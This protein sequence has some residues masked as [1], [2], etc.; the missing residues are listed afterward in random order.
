MDIF[1]ARQPIFDLHNQLFGYELLYRASSAVNAAE[2][3]TRDQMSSTV[4]ARSIIDIGLERITG[5]RIGFLNFSR[6]TLLEGFAELLSAG[7][8]VIEL[9]ETIE[10]EPAVVE[11]CQRL[12]RLGYTLAL[13]DF[14]YHP[15]YDALIRQ[16]QIVKLDVLNRSGEEIERLVAP[17]R[18]YGVRLL[19][20]R[21]ED[22]EVY[23][24]CR[25]LGCELFQGYH[26]SRP[27]ILSKRDF[28]A[29][30]ASI[31]NLMNLLRD[32]TASE[33]RIEEA[34][35]GDLALTYKLLRIVN[36]AAVGGRS[37]ESILH[38][39]QLIGR[40]ALGR[41][42]GLLLV[43]TLGSGSGPNRELALAAMA[44]GR[45]CE[46]YAQEAG[47]RAQVGPMFMVGLF[48][49]LDALMGMPLD[50]ILE[51]LDLSR[52]AHDALLRRR[53]P[54]APPLELIEAYER[55]EWERVATLATNL[56][57]SPHQLSTRYLDSLSWA[58]ERMTEAAMQ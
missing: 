6:E 54:L 50:E 41:W 47:R 30:P 26:F 37:V 4:I 48:S 56:E 34:F 31:L 7:S 27:E 15:R 13:D 44:R 49:L 29:L 12:R 58:Q 52:D 40:A 51:S 57:I 32:D 46:V 11:A 55:G 19:A 36:S 38:A 17:L 33:V 8:L 24:T 28:A 53:G 1:L 18:P 5:G 42:L 25:A 2:G 21:V 14:E 45:F 3:A 20:E 22:R 23:E 16:V 9:L 35:R 43:G 10:P 39:I